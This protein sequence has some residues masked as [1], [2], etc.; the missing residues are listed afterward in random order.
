MAPPVMTSSTQSHGVLVAQ[1]RVKTHAF[2]RHTWWFAAQCYPL[3]AHCRRCAL[4]LVGILENCREEANTAHALGRAKGNTASTGAGT[5]DISVFQALGGRATPFPE[6]QPWYPRDQHS[7]LLGLLWAEWGNLCY[8]WQFQVFW[9]VWSLF[10][11]TGSSVGGRPD[12]MLRC[13]CSGQMTVT[14]LIMV[15]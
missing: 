4:P 2:Q 14:D 3:A 13:S 9:G 15:V 6:G 7:L 8:G 1:S 11:Q 5:N 10:K 12:V